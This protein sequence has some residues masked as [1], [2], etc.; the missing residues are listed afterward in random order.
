MT[1]SDD[2]DYTL[3]PDITLDTPLGAVRDWLFDRLVTGETCPCCERT[4]RMYKRPL[5]GVHA[6]LMLD[7]W[8]VHLADPGAQWVNIPRLEKSKGGDEAKARFW[9]LIEPQ[10]GERPDGS[11]RTG[12]WRLTDRGRAFLRGELTVPKRAKIYG[13]KFYGFV[14]GDP[15]V[16]IA[17]I[18]DDQFDYDRLMR[19]E[20]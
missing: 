4:A 13:G 1:A 10:P 19:G 5:Y 14:E 7:L 15:L 20:L 9:G 8:N 3:P 12:W 2:D 18:M 17:D 11:T 16:G 6:R